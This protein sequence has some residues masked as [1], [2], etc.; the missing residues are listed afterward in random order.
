MLQIQN[1]S[2]EKKQVLGQFKHFFGRFLEFLHKSFQIN[3]K[4]SPMI[5]IFSTSK[6][7]ATKNG[8]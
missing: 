8:F 7:F 1:K 6:E 5:F 3:I 4:F 2:T